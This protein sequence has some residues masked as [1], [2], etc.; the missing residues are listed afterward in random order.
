MY[1]VYR[2]DFYFQCF[3]VRLFSTKEKVA[4]QK[5]TIDAEK[6]DEKT[7]TIDTEKEDEKTITIDTIPDLKD[8]PHFK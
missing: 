3:Q 6:K 7:R 5:V 8:L 1:M 4:E 2:Y